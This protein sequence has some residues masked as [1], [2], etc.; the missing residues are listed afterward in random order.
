MDDALLLL[1]FLCNLAKLF[2]KVDSSLS[3]YSFSCLQ[4]LCHIIITLK[5]ATQKRM[6]NK[7][8]QNTQFLIINE[9]IKHCTK[10]VVVLRQIGE[11]HYKLDLTFT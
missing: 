3:A 10:A 9:I 6:H 8:K 7:M 5:E 1:A 11:I 2:T 4:I